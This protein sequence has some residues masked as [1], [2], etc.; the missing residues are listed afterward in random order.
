MEVA[1]CVWVDCEDATAGGTSIPVN[2][3]AVPLIPMKRPMDRYLTSARMAERVFSKNFICRYFSPSFLTFISSIAPILASNIVTSIH[4]FVKFIIS[5]VF[6][7]EAVRLSDIS[8]YPPTLTGTR[9]ARRG[10][11]I[12]RVKKK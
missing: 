5:T 6:S 12:V 11:S 1:V 2:S 3:S 7:I 10:E 8:P 4:R 9:S